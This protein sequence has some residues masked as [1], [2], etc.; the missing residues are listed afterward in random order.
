MSD[1]DRDAEI[2]AALSA[3]R[4][5]LVS[6]QGPDETID[7]DAIRDL[8]AGRLDARDE[9]A[10]LDRLALAPD[11]RALLASLRRSK[12][13]RAFDR[14]LVGPIGSIDPLGATTPPIYHLDGPHGGREGGEDPIFGP[15]DR[16][17]LIARPMAPVALPPSLTVWVG[18]RD[19]P[20]VPVAQARVQRDDAGV[21][22]VLL[23]AR[24]VF[25]ASGRW[26]LV[27][28]LGDEEMGPGRAEETESMVQVLRA[29][30]VYDAAR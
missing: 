19:G 25:N 12:T 21:F 29:W 20:L 27:L 28:V 10:L 22:R 3:L 17:E 7:S 6:T 23:P 24:E 18:R 16:V 15:R 30:A 8:V 2:A 1:G 4:H 11:M 5:A 14:H 13:E 9:A 26:R